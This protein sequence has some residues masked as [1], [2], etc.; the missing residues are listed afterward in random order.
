MFYVYLDKIKFNNISCFY[1]GNSLVVLNINILSIIFRHY[2]LLFIHLIGD[3]LIFT[4]DVSLKSFSYSNFIIDVIIFIEAYF[5]YFYCSWENE[6][7]FWDDFIFHNMFFSVFCSILMYILSLNYLCFFDFENFLFVQS[8][9]NILFIF[10]NIVL[11]RGNFWEKI[12]SIHARLKY[13]WNVREREKANS[14]RPWDIYE[15]L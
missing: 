2:I 6:R 9:H 13:C 15:D 8:F 4:E 3:S 14:T 11:W 7:C 12:F 1:D 5:C 10:Q